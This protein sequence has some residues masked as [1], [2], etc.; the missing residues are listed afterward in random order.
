MGMHF[1]H[2]GMMGLSPIGL[3]QKRIGAR[4]T[5]RHVLQLLLGTGFL[6]LVFLTIHQSAHFMHVQVPPP[7]YL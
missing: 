1:A 7:K 6:L 2:S 5:V 3:S 4:R